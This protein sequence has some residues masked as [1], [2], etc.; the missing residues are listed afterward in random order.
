[1]QM[2]PLQVLLL[3]ALVDG[4][5]VAAGRYAPISVM[6]TC[7]RCGVDHGGSDGEHRVSSPPSEP[8][9]HKFVLCRLHRD[10]LCA[11]KA[12]FLVDL[13]RAK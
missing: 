12:S 6:L 7:C 10:L 3:L 5:A 4:G 1:M 8:L 13:F 2:E 9:L 11:R